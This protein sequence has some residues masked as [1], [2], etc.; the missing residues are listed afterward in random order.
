MGTPFRRR[1]SD[2]YSAVSVVD[3]EPRETCCV[4][5]HHRIETADETECPQTIEGGAQLLR[6][7]SYPRL[8]HREGE[9]MSLRKAC[10]DLTLHRGKG[11]DRLLLTRLRR[12]D[13]G[14]PLH[15]HVVRGG[16][17][18]MLVSRKSGI[19]IG[20]SVEYAV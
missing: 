4:T 10:Q 6:R 1:Q 7:R 8:K 17:N 2:A 20:T 14:P 15:T 16:C 19:H 5:L 9:L 11:R 3:T 12:R 13:L 18:T